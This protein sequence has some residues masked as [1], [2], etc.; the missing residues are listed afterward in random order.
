MLRRWGV[1]CIA[2]VTAAKVV[3][4]VRTERQLRLRPKEAR[5][6]DGRTRL[7]DLWA[8]G[9]AACEAVL[10]DQGNRHFER[11]RLVQLRIEGA[12][13]QVPALRHLRHDGRRSAHDPAV[14]RP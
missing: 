3:D 5:F 1:M 12:A 13:G 6:P 10:T 11:L 2:P 8:V 7:V 14:Q 4:G 9:G